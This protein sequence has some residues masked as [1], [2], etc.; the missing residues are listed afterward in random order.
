[1]IFGP[2]TDK[3]DE[4][5]QIKFMCPHCGEIFTRLTNELIPTH[6]W[7]R[8]CR[9]VCPGSGQVPRNPDSDKRPLWKDLQSV[10]QTETK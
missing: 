1:M 9:Q 3:V 4:M 8:P 10:D 5:R 7:P 2:I 6:D